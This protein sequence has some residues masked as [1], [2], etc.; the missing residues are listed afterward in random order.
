MRRE[1][2]WGWNGDVCAVW[3]VATVLGGG[4]TLAETRLAKEEHAR[5]IA[6]APDL[7]EALTVLERVATD[8]GIRTDA[9]RA[10]IAKATGEQ[11]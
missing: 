8:M 1:W 6:A 5:L 3:G 7:L 10:A 4:S 11:A 2:T 9:A